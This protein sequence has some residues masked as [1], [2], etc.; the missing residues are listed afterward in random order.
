MTKARDSHATPVGV[1]KQA[2][3]GTTMFSLLSRLIRSAYESS[4]ASIATVASP[5]SGYVQGRVLPGGF[6]FGRSGVVWRLPWAMI[7]G[8]AILARRPNSLLEAS[9]VH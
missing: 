8:S 7:S 9:M 6:F 3:L 2:L 5:Q 4:Y 1:S